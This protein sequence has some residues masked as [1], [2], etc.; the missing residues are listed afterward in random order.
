M[1][2][3]GMLLGTTS[4]IFSTKV[5]NTSVL[6]VGRGSEGC[7]AGVLLVVA[8][9]VEATEGLRFLFAYVT[10]A[11]PL[12]DPNV[13]DCIQLTSSKMNTVAWYIYLQLFPSAYSPC[14]FPCDLFQTFASRGLRR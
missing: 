5:S 13:C 7:T 8:A 11:L 14:H 3:L 1:S 9:D 10:F 2:L 4:S 12:A 6:E